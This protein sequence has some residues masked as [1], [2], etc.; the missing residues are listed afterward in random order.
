MTVAVRRATPVDFDAWYELRVQVAGEGIWIGAELP[1][2]RNEAAF[3]A[4]LA[5]PDAV[6]LLAEDGGRLAGT[7]G[8]ECTIGIASF[9]MWVASSHRGRGVGRALVDAYVEWAAN[10]G[11]H[12]VSIEVWPHNG[13]ALALYQSAGFAIEGR[14]RR[15]YRRRSGELWDALLMG[16]VLDAASPGSPHADANR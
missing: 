4:H 6:T 12:K 14:K 9:G 2:E 7:I 10:V 16:K 5:R 11:A 15:H 3:V 13:A 8:G 1:I